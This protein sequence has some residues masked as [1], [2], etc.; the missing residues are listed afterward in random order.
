MSKLY[1]EKLDTEK[2]AELE[3][4][5]LAKAKKL[6]L[7][8]VADAEELVEKVNAALKEH[9]EAVETTEDEADKVVQQIFKVE[10]ARETVFDFGSDLLGLQGDINRHITALEQSADDL[11]LDA[12]NIPVYSM[13][14]LKIE[15][16]E[17]AFGEQSDRLRQA[18]DLIKAL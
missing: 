9:K 6:K 8:L 18:E 16:I 17:T 11:G 10:A 1:F 14:E 2:L 5:E 7:S 4:V 3:K 13:L 12:D 15:D